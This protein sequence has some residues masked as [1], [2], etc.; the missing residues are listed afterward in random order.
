MAKTSFDAIAL[1]IGQFDKKMIA[2]ALNGL[3]FASQVRVIRNASLNGTLLP[4]MT[5]AKGIR[6]L[7]LDVETRS[8][9]HRTFG[10]RKLMVYP[11]MKIIDII[12]EEAY[13]TFLSDMMAPGAKQ[14]PFAQWV[15]EQEFAKLASEINDNIYLSKYK[16]DAAVWASGS[17]YTANTSYVK[18]GSEN[19]VYKCVTNTNAGESPTTHPA[20]WSKV[21]ELIIS[22]GWGS[23]IATEIAA[24]NITPVTTGAVDATNALTKVEAML[25]A[26]TVAHRNLGGVIRMS[27][28]LYDAYLK[29]ERATYTAAATPTMGTGEKTVYGY[30]KWKIESCSWMG[31]SGRII[32]TQFDNLVFGTNMIDDTNKAGKTIETLHGTSTVVKWIQ[33]CEIA[34][35]ETLYVN[36]QA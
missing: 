10:G 15:W 27:P 26:M 34:D 23:I 32:A 31:S 28:V 19:D 18:F 3:D 24:S 9:S 35:L 4:K 11:G 16:G 25:T 13:K 33:G 17:T 1:H 8:G 14:M 6:N 20:K 29:H 7:D 30:P 2:Q 5:V 21:N 12:P 22:E 36:D